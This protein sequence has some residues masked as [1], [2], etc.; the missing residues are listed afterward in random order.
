MLYLSCVI[1]EIFPHWS[2]IHRWWNLHQLVAHLN[3]C[4]GRWIVVS[5][6]P[7]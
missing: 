3:E 6:R 7:K 1:Y 5:I 2:K 4:H